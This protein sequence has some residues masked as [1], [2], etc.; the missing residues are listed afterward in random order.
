[1]PRGGKKA[2]AAEGP[3]I[4]EILANRSA[5]ATFAGLF[6]GNYYWYFL[7]T[8]LPYYLVHERHFSMETMAVVGAVPFLCSAA[9][10]A[11]AG[12][13]SYRALAAGATPTRVRKT[14]TTVGLGLA[15]L[16]VLVPWVDDPRGAMVVLML[17]CA[18]YGIYSTSPWA[19]AQTISGPIAAGRWAGFQNFIANLSGVVAPALTG[20]VV[21]RTG[22]FQWAFGLTACFALAGAVVYL[23]VLGKVEPARWSYQASS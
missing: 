22:N 7:I 15:S 2:A 5:W 3:T 23:F 1:M 20:L 13:L 6:C 16:I 14:C 21:E 8:W 9:A 10:T 17:A 11:V 19:I 18:S 12:W 4:G